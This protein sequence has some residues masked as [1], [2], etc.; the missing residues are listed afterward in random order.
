[1]KFSKMFNAEIMRQISEI[2]AWRRRVTRGTWLFAQRP[3]PDPPGASPRPEG[4]PGAPQERLLPWLSLSH[5]VGADI[6]ASAGSQLPPRMP[7][8]GTECSRSE[9]P[10]PKGNVNNKELWR[11]EANNESLRIKPCHEHIKRTNASRQRCEDG[12][13]AF[14]QDCVQSHVKPVTD[15]SGLWVLSRQACFEA[16]TWPVK[17]RHHGRSSPLRESDSGSM[18]ICPIPF[19]RMPICLGSSPA[20]SYL[21]GV[22]FP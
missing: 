17:L 21:C 8:G 10:T 18:S 2:K 20:S 12:G 5:T 3:T 7:P 9:P 14:E 13:V 22:D 4:V 16:R 19:L 15:T 6:L 11:S 1:M